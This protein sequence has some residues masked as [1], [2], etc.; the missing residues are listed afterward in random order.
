MT[1]LTPEQLAELE[2]LEAAA[3]PG[4]WRSVRRGNQ[5]INDQTTLVGASEVFGIKRPWNAASS[6]APIHQEDICRFTDEDADFIA[7]AKRYTK[8]L[9]EEV[10]ELRAEAQRLQDLFVMDDGPWVREA[11][12]KDRDALKR[13]LA[14]M[15]AE[16]ERLKAPWKP[17]NSCDCSPEET[18]TCDRVDCRRTPGA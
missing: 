1:T 16:I 12:K 9:I 13:Q 10:R 14:E 18:L 2:R 3:T 15:G 8:P 17:R 6:P 5:Y 11:L 7:A 4:D